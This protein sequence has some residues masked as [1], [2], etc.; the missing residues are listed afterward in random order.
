MKIAALNTIRRLEKQAHDALK[1]G[2]KSLMEKASLLCAEYIHAFKQSRDALKNL[3]IVIFAG[4]GNNGGDGILCGG[5]LNALYNEKVTIYSLQHPKDMSDEIRRHF[6]S[7]PSAVSVKFIANDGQM[8]DILKPC[9]IVDALLGIG[10]KGELRGSAEKIVNFINSVNLPVVSIDIPSGIECDSG[11]GKNAVFADMTITVGAEK[12]GLY[13][14]DGRIHS[15]TV[16]FADIGFDL[17]EIDEN[18]VEFEVIPSDLPN[19]FFTRPQTEFYKQKNGRLLIAGGSKTYPGAAVLSILGAN[20]A[21]CGLLTAAIKARPFCTLP[22]SVIARDFSADGAECF[23]ENDIT[24]LVKIA[25]NQDAVVFGMGV[26]AN[27]DTGKVLQS[28]IQLPQ[29]LILDADALNIIAM[30]PEIWQKKSHNN[31]I[32]TPH[33]QE[34]LRLAKAFKISGFETMPRYKQSEIL[35]QTLNCTV[36]LKGDKTLISS[37][38]CRTWVNQCGSYA[39][40]KGGSGDI[41]S[42]IIGALSAKNKKYP[43]HYAAALGVFIHSASADFAAQSRSAFDI[44]TLPDAVQQYI[45]S[46]T[47]F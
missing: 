14:A 3:D 43:P 37:P 15:G 13:L 30:F 45:N 9:L 4:K 22:P 35:A 42:G 47:I 7:L 25:G 41:L 32:I 40:A 29:T 6:F 39:L 19:K 44:N 5:C 18:E 27:A 17:T 16:K 1:P 2:E 21:G 8:T 36:V 12:K 24:E 28:L 11:I 26:T 20:A 10:F 23:N 34:A 33:S 31:I 38:N 46:I